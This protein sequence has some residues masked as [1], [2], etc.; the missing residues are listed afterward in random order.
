LAK[1][2][3]C[4][5]LGIAPV[6][7]LYQVD[8]FPIPGAKIDAV[9]LTIQGG[10]PIPT[11]M[12]TLGKLGMKTGLIAA[13]G[14]D[15]FG[16]F[17]IKELKRF[18]VD[19]SYILRK[20]SST[21]VAAGWFE[22]RSGRRTIILDLKI[23]V[24]PEE[25]ILEKLPVCRAVHLDGRDLAACMKLARW[26]KKKGVTVVFDIGARRND[27]SPIFPLVDHLVCAEEFA[28]PFTGARNA[29][30]AVEKLS[31]LCTRTIIVTSG[32]KGAVG[33][34]PSDGWVRQ[35]AFRIQTIDTTG[36]G[37]VYHGAYIYGML[38]GWRLDKRMNFAAAAAAL[39]CTRPGGRLGI[40]ARGEVDKFL[41]GR[42][43][44]YD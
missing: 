29:K 10:G 41:S 16:D 21:A 18:H 44:M 36:A 8:K 4:L 17:V 3:D 5:G 22:K 42:R 13:A 12:A 7:I 34:S 15:L 35:K 1:I 30:R 25:L 20:D 6:D 24:K 39:K 9:S 40:P 2:L 27:V 32:S 43:L 11:A 28:L 26:A 23:R 31:I 33:Y 14:K 19:T 37:D 38:S